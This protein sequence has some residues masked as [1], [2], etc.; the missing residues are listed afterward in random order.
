MGK[1]IISTVMEL[2]IE[3]RT[4]A[5]VREI[6]LSKLGK[7]ESFL[8]NWHPTQAINNFQ[9]FSFWLNP[10]IPLQFIF[11][12]SKEPE[13]NQRWLDALEETCHSIRG[14]EILEEKQVEDFLASVQA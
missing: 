2:E 13:L 3:D 4:L 14:L 8:I 10:G 5:H 11:Y 12:G 9:R 1:L 7:Q 6:V